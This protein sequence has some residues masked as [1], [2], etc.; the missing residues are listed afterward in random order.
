M[1]RLIA[2]VADAWECENL[3]HPFTDVEAE[4]AQAG[5]NASHALLSR[6]PSVASAVVTLH[7]SGKHAGVSK[8]GTDSTS[9]D[10][11]K[12]LSGVSCYAIAFATSAAALGLGLAIQR[13]FNELSPFIVFYAAVAVSSWCG[14]FGPGL[15]AVGLGAL[16][17][18]YYLLEPR[19]SFAVHDTAAVFRLAL[20]VAVGTLIARLNGQL[21]SVN[22]DARAYQRRLAE[23]S[24]ELVDAEGRERR[25]IASVLHDSIGQSLALAK[26]SLQSVSASDDVAPAT[27]KT[28]SD[29]ER[30]LGDVIQETRSLTS[31]LSPPVLFELGLVPALHWLAERMLAQ[32]GLKVDVDAADVPALPEKQSVALFE[33]ASELLRNVVRHAH[34]G[35]AVVALRCHAAGVRM[36]VSDDGIGFDS[37]QTATAAGSHEGFGLFSV[38]ERVRRFGGT[39]RISAQADRGTAVTIELP[40]RPGAAAPI[41]QGG[42]DER[43]PSDHGGFAHHPHPAR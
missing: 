34:A 37:K 7:G 35:R 41:Q 10:V 36:T 11:P 15:V 20:F 21:L 30:L 40:A 3:S 28:I 17:C 18:D 38:R 5:A 19:F 26:M 42:L 9:H 4:T 1:S 13:P 2:R 12:R 43:Q 6:R 16:A 33:I 24:G 29:V 22:A 14:G 39:F 32:R 8:P 27:A 31:E 23:L 25:R